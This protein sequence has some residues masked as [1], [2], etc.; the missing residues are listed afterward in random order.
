MSVNLCKDFHGTWCQRLDTGVD[1]TLDIR[2]VT[3][4]EL[5]SPKSLQVE[6]IPPEVISSKA[7][8]ST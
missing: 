4:E 3:D 6:V 7:N 5:R 1:R 8:L 2:F